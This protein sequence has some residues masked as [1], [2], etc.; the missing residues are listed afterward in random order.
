MSRDKQDRQIIGAIK[1]LLEPGQEKIIG[2]GYMINNFAIL[3]K[4]FENKELI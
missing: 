4:V 1:L 2:K 3:M